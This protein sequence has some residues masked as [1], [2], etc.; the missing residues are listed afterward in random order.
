MNIDRIMVSE[1]KK[2][3]KGEYIYKANVLKVIDGDTFDVDIDLGFRI[4]TY[5]RLR[6]VDVDTPEIRG[7]ERPEGLKVK[8]YVKELIDKK[9]VLIQI[10]KVG[11]YGRYVAEVFLENKEKLSVHLLEKNMAKKVSY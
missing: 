11:K 8:E 5:Q 10:F 7:E 9:E 2:L 4:I 3:K 6:L 1:N